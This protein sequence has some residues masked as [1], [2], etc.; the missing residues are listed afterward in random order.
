MN[1]TA[2]QFKY[3]NEIVYF[4]VAVLSL[5][6]GAGNLVLAVMRSGMWANEVVG[7]SFFV[8][9]IITSIFFWKFPESKISMY[10]ISISWLVVYS[11]AVCVY[12]IIEV[13]PVSFVIMLACVAYMDMKET[14]I[15]NFTSVVAN[16]AKYIFSKAVLD[17]NAGSSE[18]LCVALSLIVC[19]VSTLITYL[20]I[21]FTRENSE[22]LLHI[23]EK[24]KE[25][26]KIVSNTTSVMSSEFETLVEDLNIINEQAEKNR[27]SMHQVATGMDTTASEIQNQVVSTNS[28][29]N[30]IEQTGDNA[31]QVLSTANQVL[32]TVEVGIETS[33]E[34]SRHSKLVDENVN[35][36]SET[37]NKLFKRVNDV[38]SI[39][40]TIL[41]ISEQTNLLALNASIEAARAGDA[42]RGFA[43]VA[44]EI[45]VL[46]EDTRT[47]TSKITD[48]VKDL[49]KETHN[50][51]DGLEQSVDSIKQEEKKIDEVNES[52]IHTGSA[53]KELCSLLEIIREDVKNVSESNSSIVGV[54]GHISGTTQEVTA[55]SQESS[56]M[57]DTIMDKIHSFNDSIV[58]MKQ[59]INELNKIVNESNQSESDQ[60]ENI[61]TEG[62]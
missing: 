14:M 41:A 62:N 18:S 33:S 19:G 32:D 56:G 8:C 21:K 47:S 24:E 22:N 9:L 46:S 61:L 44:D 2:K 34:V 40:D 52:F 43:V 13:Y 38:Y 31:N 20:L 23:L 3:S 4:C 50:M 29:Q 11:L 45:R 53:I 25:T 30:A 1:L 27:I 59:M 10:V 51:M 42:G 35:S 17:L 57:S 48:I 49:T 36:M 16:L 12:D 39:T 6:L 60:M 7:I 26:A 5:L 28:I 37:M 54:I 55:V 58:S 15:V